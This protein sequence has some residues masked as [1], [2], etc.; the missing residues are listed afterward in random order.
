MKT[1]SAKPTTIDDYIAAF[2]TD[3]QE[4]L[5]KVRETIKTAAPQATEAISY[6]M[7]T[8]KLEGNL[9]HFGAFK[10]HLGFYPVPSGLE[11]FKEELAQ[12][13]GGKGS[14]QFPYDRPMPYALI[15]KIVQFRVTENLAK[16]AAKK[17]KK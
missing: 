3:V 8:F 14:V 5:Q 10:E 11:Q 2:P 9:V 1:E 13:K 7:P 6:G 4:I 12:Y 17:K 15:T 16:A